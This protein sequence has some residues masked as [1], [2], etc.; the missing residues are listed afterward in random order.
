[1]PYYL[2]KN[3]ETEEICELFFHMNDEKKFIDESGIEWHREFVVPQASIDTNIDPYSKRAFMDKTNKAGTF[4]EMMDLSK[5]L[6]EK[7][8]GGKN[9]PVK[10]DFV[11]NWKQ[12][13]NLTKNGYTPSF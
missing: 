10:K 6:S 11:K 9:D 2:F 8:G 3:P 5:E 4:G 13:R 1:M 7:R 12:K